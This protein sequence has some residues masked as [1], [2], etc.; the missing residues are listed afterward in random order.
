MYSFYSFSFYIHTYSLITVIV[1]IGKN[2]F[3]TFL[4]FIIIIF[5][6]LCV[7]IISIEPIEI[8]PIIIQCT[9]TF[10]TTLVF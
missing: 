2:Q 8:G 9:W 10:S 1:G 3:R 7:G 6:L 5:F 4:L